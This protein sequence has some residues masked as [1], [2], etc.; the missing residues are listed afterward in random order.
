MYVHSKTIPYTLCIINLHHLY[1]IYS[2]TDLNILPLYNLIQHRISCM[3]YTLVNGL[4]PEV[5]NELYTTNDQIHD[6]FIRQY[7]F[8][9]INKGRS[10]VYTRSFGNISP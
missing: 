1:T 6:Y 8:F 3:M 9:H 2:N 7:H 4:L 10:N 5:M